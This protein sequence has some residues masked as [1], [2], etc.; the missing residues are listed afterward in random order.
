MLNY[1]RLKYY[2]ATDVN[3]YEQR[4]CSTHKLIHMYN[5]LTNTAYT[6]CKNK[7]RSGIQRKQFVQ[8]KVTK[9]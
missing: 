1:D 4:K 6:G 9:R 2:I 3:D 8:P 5:K 7:R